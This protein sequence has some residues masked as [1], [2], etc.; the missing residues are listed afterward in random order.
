MAAVDRDSVAAK[1]ALNLIK[2]DLTKAHPETAEV[3]TDELISS[4]VK[5]AKVK[6]LTPPPDPRFPAQNVSGYCWYGTCLQGFASR[7]RLTWL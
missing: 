6:N 7:P 4:S 5:L 3:V 2:A 1:V